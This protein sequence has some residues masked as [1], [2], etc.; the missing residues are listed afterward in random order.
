MNESKPMIDVRA[1]VTAAYEYMKSIQDL[2]GNPLDDLRLEEVE[3]SNDKSFWLI[4]LGFERPVKA[5]K[6]PLQE[7]I[8][9]SAVPSSTSLYQREYKQ[10]KVNSQTGEV[11]AM[12]IREL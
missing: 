3:L 2:M 9:A 10:F 5:R 12:K 11:E 6:S 4:T 8:P 1:A 7:L